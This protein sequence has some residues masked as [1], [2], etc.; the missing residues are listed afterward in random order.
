MESKAAL[1]SCQASGSVTN[2]VKRNTIWLFSRTRFLIVTADEIV[3]KTIEMANHEVNKRQH[4]LT[5]EADANKTNP[6]VLL[7]PT[8]IVP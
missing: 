6:F 3:K 4:I 2:E 7:R 8:Q 5:L 1:D